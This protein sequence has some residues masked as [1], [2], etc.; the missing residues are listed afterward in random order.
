MNDSVGV[1]SRQGKRLPPELIARVIEL[2]EAGLPRDVVGGQVGISRH[3][4]SRI[5]KGR[6]RPIRPPKPT[7]S[8]DLIAPLWAA[9]IRIVEISERLGTA[10]SN[11]SSRVSDARM[12]GDER[13]PHRCVQRGRYFGLQTRAGVERPCLRCSRPFP[14]TGPT[15]RLCDVCNRRAADVSPFDPDPCVS[16]SRGR[17]VTSHA[18][19][20]G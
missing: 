10:P 20:V 11:V 15:N 8:L 19:R 16:E 3:A 14:S 4:V 6:G 17:R 5:M 9:G 13:F 7:I 12:A 18:A 2:V 1:S